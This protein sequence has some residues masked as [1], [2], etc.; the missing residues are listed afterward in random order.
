MQTLM[1]HRELTVIEVFISRKKQKLS[2]RLT[3]E[4]PFHG[5]RF[6]FVSLNIPFRNHNSGNTES[7][8]FLSLRLAA[9]MFHNTLRSVTWALPS[10]NQDF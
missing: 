7:L 6:S 10:N 9:A 3:V 8:F 4:T 5:S 2:F 1:K